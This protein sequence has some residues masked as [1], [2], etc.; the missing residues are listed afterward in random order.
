MGVHPEVMIEA[1]DAITA[2]FL[3]G[4]LVTLSYS[5]FAE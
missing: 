1:L 3:L 4:C 2:L 5:L